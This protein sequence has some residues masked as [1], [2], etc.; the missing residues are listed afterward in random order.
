LRQDP[1][2]I[3]DASQQASQESRRGI[4]MKDTEQDAEKEGDDTPDCER[5]QYVQGDID[6]SGNLG[7]YA[8]ANTGVRSP[9]SKFHPSICVRIFTQITNYQINRA[10]TRFFCLSAFPPDCSFGNSA[11]LPHF[12]QEEEWAK[13]WIPPEGG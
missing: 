11:A 4:A 10:A 3:N 1:H 6:I 12:L 13:A 5:C 7:E 8:N 9:C 2:A